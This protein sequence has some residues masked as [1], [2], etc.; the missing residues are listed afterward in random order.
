L[1]ANASHMP[2]PLTLERIR[3]DSG[4]G[5]IFLLNL[6]KYREPAGR[7]AFAKY[8][9]ITGMFRAADLYRREGAAGLRN[10]IKVG[11]LPASPGMP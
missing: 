4:A 9:A 8:A 10:V 7:E 11:I 3:N 1:S 2:D 6:L 5:P